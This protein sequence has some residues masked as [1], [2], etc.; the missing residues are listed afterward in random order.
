VD[1]IH[2]RD[3]SREHVD[4]VLGVFQRQRRGV[5]LLERACFAFNA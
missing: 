5:H 3:A 4:R 1:R 2:P